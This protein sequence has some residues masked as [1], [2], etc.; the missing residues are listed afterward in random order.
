[1]TNPFQ[2]QVISQLERMLRENRVVVFYDP[3]KEFE[4][5]IDKLEQIDSGLGGLPRVQPGL[6]EGGGCGQGRET[7]PAN[8]RSKATSHPRVSASTTSQAVRTMVAPPQGDLAA[9]TRYSY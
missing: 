3:R 8:A 6:R 7:P 2:Q 1:M 5:L 4:A 9:G